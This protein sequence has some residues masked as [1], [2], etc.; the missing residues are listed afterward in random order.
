MRTG[1]LAA[2]TG[3]L[4][5]LLGGLIGL[6]GAEFRLPF[7][8]G[9]LGLAPRAAVP[10][11]LVVSFVTLA[12]AL[13]SRLW[14][15]DPAPIAALA[16]EIV[17]L[18]LGG[19]VSAFAVPALLARLSDHRLARLLGLL[20][21]AIGLLLVLEAFLPGEPVRLAPRGVLGT[22]LAGFLLG[23]LIGAV[24]ALLGVAGGELLVATF[25]FRFWAA[26]HT[27]GTASVLV[28][29]LLVPT[30]LLRYGRLGALPSGPVLHEVVLPM[31]SGSILGAGL[32]GLTAGLVPAAALKLLLGL[33]LILS[34]AKVLLAGHAAKA[35]RA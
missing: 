25:L 21:V 24:A 12:T 34:A 27:A 16:L 15:L 32:G 35:Q 31:P 28:S 10:A 2:G 8:V 9:L 1:L 7:L 13:S 23:L 5:A 20:L 19:L 22:I 30:A 14:S 26:V 6:G 4:I 11:N 3:A 29:L 33:V 17:A 18:A